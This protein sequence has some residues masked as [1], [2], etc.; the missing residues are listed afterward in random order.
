MAQLC[1]PKNPLALECGLCLRIMKYVSLLFR[2]ATA[3]KIRFSLRISSVNVTKSIVSRGFNHI[4]LMENFIFCVVCSLC[5][6]YVKYFIWSIN[7]NCYSNEIMKKRD[8]SSTI[9]QIAGSYL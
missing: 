5:Q 3:Q 6:V 1:K 7:T 8:K 2:L 4:Y 9:S